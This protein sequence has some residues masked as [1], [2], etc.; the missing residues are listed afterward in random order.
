MTN[1]KL[2]REHL[3]QLDTWLK[4]AMER[5]AKRG[6]PVDGVLFHAGELATYHR[7]DQEIPFRP[8]PHFARWVPLAGPSH[9]VLARPGKKPR[10]VRVA[11]KDFWYEHV[12]PPKSYWQGAVDLVEVASTDE[13]KKALGPLDRVAYVGSSPRLASSFG[14]SP[15]QQEPDAIL[16]PLDWYR[17][18]KTPHEIAL[19]TIAAERAAAGHAA[20]RDAF[21]AGL[22]ERE[23]HWKY[24]EATGHLES[25]MPFGTIVAYDD[26]TA[27]LHYQN[28]R[29]A[30]PT[31]K[32]T[33]ML[34][35]GATC[36]GYASDITR[37][38]VKRDAHPVFRALLLGLDAFQRQLVAMVTPGRPY[39]E[40]HLAA[41][42]H[43]AALLSETRVV[44]ATAEET[45]ARGLTRTFLPHGVGHHLGL[46]VH[47]VGG[48][49]A[50]PEGGTTPPPAEHR[51]LRNTR[52]LEPGHLVTIE[53][54]IYFMPVL[55]E[56]L[57]ARP[58]GE[59]VDWKLVDK[60]TPFGGMRIEDDVLVTAK[61]PRDLTRGLIA[62]P[63]G[64][65]TGAGKR[66]ARR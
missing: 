38:W 42:R 37:T 15:I 26:K 23:I 51:F 5:A 48:H 45:L 9:C 28:K 14:I 32:R 34:D 49:Q 60:L 7:D 18:I 66:R 12:S 31:R 50:S 44:R 21:D 52:M 58:E 56:E 8:T 53:P 27:T 61:E 55:L 59:L 4:D 24:L 41:H 57:H 25:E 54:G 1:A 16:K 63:G 17:A 36:D 65:K 11:P 64:A 39:L 6:R 33:F 40:I 47:D 20:A 62:G 35:A 3:K 46:Q 22:N 30:I 2:Y 43:V 29:T 13:L 10:V 19:V